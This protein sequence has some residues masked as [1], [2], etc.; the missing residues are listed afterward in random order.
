MY[1]WTQ[2]YF[3]LKN[4]ECSLYKIFVAVFIENYFTFKKI[5]LPF[6]TLNTFS[7][8]L[9]EGTEKEIF[10]REILPHFLW[11]LVIAD[12]LT[13]ATSTPN[14]TLHHVVTSLIGVFKIVWEK[15]RDSYVTLCLAYKWLFHTNNART[16]IFLFHELKKR[17]V[18]LKSFNRE[19]KFLQPFTE[20]TTKNC[21]LIYYHW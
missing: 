7:E 16:Y 5:Y 15:K 4:W 6:N 18:H 9:T 20:A 3:L 10:R 19:D 11:I 12:P 13:R 21:P 14:N 1:W 17:K 2:I 8:V